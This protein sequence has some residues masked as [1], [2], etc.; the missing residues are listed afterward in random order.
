MPRQSTVKKPLDVTV[1]FRRIRKAIRPYPKAAMFQLADEGYR[2]VFELVVSCII[3]VRT[4]D[5][6]M[7]PVSRRLFA[8][9]RTPAAMLSLSHDEIDD[10]IRPSTF[11]ENKVH[12]IRA[13]ARRAVDEFDGQLPADPDVLLDLP[14]VGP[15]CANLV[16][17]IAAGRPCISVD[18]HVH[19]VVNRWGLVQTTTPERTMAALEEKLPR[20]RW[21]EINEL[22]MPFGKHVCTGTLPRCSTCPVLEM[23]RQIGVTTHR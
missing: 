1:A 4:R 21:V 16:L 15:K 19:R 17:G 13:I 9:A 12:S 6:T 20:R 3:S 8:K 5:E 10:L 11:H 7:L 2:S 23:C 18:V 14:G 22:L